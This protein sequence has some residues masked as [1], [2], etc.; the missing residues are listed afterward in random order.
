MLTVVTIF[1]SDKELRED[2]VFTRGLLIPNLLIDKY[3][4][5]FSFLHLLVLDICYHYYYY[6]HYFTGLVGA[7]LEIVNLLRHWAHW[8]L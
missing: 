6:Y 2:L 8:L 7:A 4:G 3:N 5:H 1:S